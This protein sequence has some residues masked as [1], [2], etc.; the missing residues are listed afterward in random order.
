MEQTY[1]VMKPLLRGQLRYPAAA[2][3]CAIPFA[4]LQGIKGFVSAFVA[5]TIFVSLVKNHTI[6]VSLVKNHTIVVYEDSL[7]EKDFR[8]RFIRKVFASQVNHY[9]KNFLNEVTLI[10]A[11]SKPRLCVEP[12]M[13]NRDC[14]EQWLA[15][16]NIES[17]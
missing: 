15:S 1:F 7:I 4:L 8:G 9:R 3:L 5:I 10:D 17:K 16:H 2:L 12:Y 14:F 11:D 13:T 6:V